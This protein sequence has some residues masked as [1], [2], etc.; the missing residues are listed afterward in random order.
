MVSEQDLDRDRL[1][2]M[3]RQVMTAEAALASC[4]A[5]VQEEANERV[6]GVCRVLSQDYHARL[7]LQEYRFCK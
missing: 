2:G 3:E 1:E 5:T 6:V 7:K 4:E